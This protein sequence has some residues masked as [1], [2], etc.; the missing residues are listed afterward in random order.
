MDYGKAFTFVF[1]DEDWIKKLVIGGIL[2][3]IPIVNFIVLGYGLKVL[4]NVAE[5]AERPLPE[6][7]DFGDYFVQGLMSFL[8]G[9]VWAIPL[10][11]VGMFS[12]LISYLTGYDVRSDQGFWYYSGNAC[13]FGLSCLSALYGLLMGAVM[14]AANT[15]YAI[16]R[17]FA[18][19]FRFGEIFKYISANLGTYIIAVLL[20]WVAQ[21]IAGFGLI[22]CCVGVVFTAFWGTLVG[23]HLMG[24]VYRF[25]TTSRP[26]AVA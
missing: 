4:K 11:L 17:E 2:S 15:K 3:L 25:S 24:Q 22:L 16:S 18:A 6:W 21:F 19:F 10:I 5:G 13:T 12:G 14:P 1:D 23:N 7:D 8:G 9:L 20:T 26:E